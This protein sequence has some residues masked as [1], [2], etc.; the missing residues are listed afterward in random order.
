MN[1]DINKRIS[2]KDKDSF[3][4]NLSK[5]HETWQVKQADFAIKLYNFFL[6]KI[7]ENDHQNTSKQDPT[8]KIS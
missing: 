8:A 1:K 4:Q 3:L 5:D 7:E 2:N 6:L